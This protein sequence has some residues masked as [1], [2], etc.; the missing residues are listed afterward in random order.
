MNG[1][2]V[3]ASFQMFWFQDQE[4]VRKARSFLEFSEDVIKVPRNLVGTEEV[5]S[6]AGC[7]TVALMCNIWIDLLQ[8][9]FFI[10]SQ[11]VT[12]SKPH[13]ASISVFFSSCIQ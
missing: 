3:V 11:S 12:L 4:A 5:L 9:L 6:W 13:R 2:G 8:I 10:K 1:A 7:T